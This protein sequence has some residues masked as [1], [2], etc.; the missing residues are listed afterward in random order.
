[1][2]LLQELEERS[3]N[4]CE[5]CAATDN[6]SIYEVPPMYTG[7]VDGSLLACSTCVEQIGDV[8]KTE[9]DCSKIS[10]IVNYKPKVSIENG[11]NHFINWYNDYY[12]K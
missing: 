7:G 1:M 4:Q 3:G 11:I 12:K 5:L 10:S 9:S 8:E 6:L 2:S